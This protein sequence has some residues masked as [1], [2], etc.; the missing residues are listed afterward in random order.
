MGLNPL[1]ASLHWVRHNWIRLSQIKIIFIL[2]L[3]AQLVHFVGLFKPIY[4]RAWS[5]LMLLLTVS[6]HDYIFYKKNQDL[7]FCKFIFKHYF[8]Q[9]Y[10]KRM[11]Q[12]TYH[13]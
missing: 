1:Q 13:H 11:R 10:T 3:L 9:L 4:G 8:A 7:F 12:F 5:I 2:I 6:S